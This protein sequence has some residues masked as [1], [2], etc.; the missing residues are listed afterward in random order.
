LEQ[1]SLDQESKKTNPDT[2]IKVFCDNRSVIERLTTIQTRKPSKMWS[3]NDLLQRC[4]KLLTR[5]FVFEHVQGHQDTISSNSNLT[6]QAKLDILMDKWAALTHS[7]PII[8]TEETTTGTIEIH[9]QTYG[10]LS[11]RDNHAQNGK[12]L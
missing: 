9:R 2:L 6:L 7:D 3:D 10:L 4:N 8:L 11:A 5:K 12:V 1:L